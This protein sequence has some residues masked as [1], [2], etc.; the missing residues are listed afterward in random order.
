MASNKKVVSDTSPLL[1]LALIDRLEALEKQFE[2]ITVPEKVWQELEEGE[3]GLDKLK[4]KRE[5]FNIV[6]VEEDSFYKELNKELDKGETAAIRHAIEK[7]ADIV[8]LDEKEGRK[9]ARRHDLKTTGVIGILIR[10]AEKGNLKLEKT[11]KELKQSGFW[12]SEE[13]EQ[14]ILKQV[15]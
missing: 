14:Q 15:N 8:L 3:K 2:E 5:I 6:K 1:N 12:I 10:E 7:D 13:L 4:Q 11:L 9:V